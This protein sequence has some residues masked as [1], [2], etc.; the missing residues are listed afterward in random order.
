MELPL[1]VLTSL[2]HFSITCCVLHHLS[3]PKFLSLW[4]NLVQ[5]S[6]SFGTFVPLASPC[7]FFVTF[8]RF[9]SFH[10]TITWWSFHRLLHLC[11]F[12]LASPGEFFITFSAP[13]FLLLK[14]HLVYYS[15]PFCFFVPFTTETCN[16]NCPRAYWP[17]N[18]TI[19]TKHIL[20]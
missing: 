11:S 9:R 4:H 2:P 16:K 10:S 14:H 6:S 13:L 20:L 19:K 8:L 1:E 7:E 17:G 5:S 12:T 18:I 15:S 3:A